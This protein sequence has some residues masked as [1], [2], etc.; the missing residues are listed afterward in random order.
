M[1]RAPDFAEI[2]RE[3]P[4][5][6]EAIRA[7]LAR[8]FPTLAEADLVDALRAAG[9]LTLSLVAVGDEGLVGHVALSRATLGGAPALALAPLAVAEGRR[10]EG[11]GSRLVRAA[12]REL[13]GSFRGAV[14]VLGDPLWYERFGFRPAPGVV[15][16]WSSPQLLALDLAGGGTPAGD[17][18]HAPAFDRL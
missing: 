11:V 6:E 13:E 18:V 17:M 9:D 14:V 2:R 8:C 15:C 16:R 5:D 12:L 7:L 3:R 1:S 10:I 4:A